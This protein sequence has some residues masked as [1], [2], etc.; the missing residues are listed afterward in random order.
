MTL[1]VRIYTGST[2]DANRRIV[3]GTLIASA[4]CPGVTV[5][6]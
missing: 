6:P 3:G 4:R 5:L 1:A 2:I